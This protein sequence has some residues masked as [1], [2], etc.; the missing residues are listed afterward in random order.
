[1][2]TQYYALTLIYTGWITSIPVPQMDI[3]YSSTISSNIPINIESI[4][5][6]IWI[7]STDPN[8]FRTSPRS[9][10]LEILSLI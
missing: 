7:G 4:S 1:M 2:T 8:C 9:I 5:E 6:N 10:S 3:F